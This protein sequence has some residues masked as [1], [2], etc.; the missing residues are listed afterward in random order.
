MIKSKNKKKINIK[1]L[2][3]SFLTAYIVSMGPQTVCYLLWFYVEN[4]LLSIKR[5]AVNNL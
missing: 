2:L 5:Y 1:K 4:A 3:K